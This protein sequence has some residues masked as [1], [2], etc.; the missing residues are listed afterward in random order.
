M[1]DIYSIPLELQ[2]FWTCGCTDGKLQTTPAR[3]LRAMV[4]MELH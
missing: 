2:S 1:T 3:N 4:T